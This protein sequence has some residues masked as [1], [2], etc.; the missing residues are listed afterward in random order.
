MDRRRQPQPGAPK[1]G[2]EAASQVDRR[3][4]KIVGASIVTLR[5]IEHHGVN[6]RTGRAALLIF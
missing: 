4:I 3:S 6:P 2:Q 1:A 5:R